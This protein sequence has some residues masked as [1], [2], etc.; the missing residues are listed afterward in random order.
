[1]TDPQTYLQKLREHVDALQ[2]WEAKFGDKTP[3]ELLNQ[4]EDHQTAITVTTQFR[5]GGLK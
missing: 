2:E 3:E 4:I 5:A 1:M